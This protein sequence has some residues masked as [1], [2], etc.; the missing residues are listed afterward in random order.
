MTALIIA[1]GM[2]SFAFM[3]SVRESTKE[4][5]ILNRE[6]QGPGDGA[7]RPDR[8]DLAFGY[9]VKDGQI[10]HRGSGSPLVG[11]DIK[12]FQPIS[13]DCGKDKNTGYIRD[14][15]VE[16]S[17]PDSF[18]CL[19]GA[20][21]KDKAHV[22]FGYNKIQTVDDADPASFEIIHDPESPTLT[23]Y[24]RDVD[25]VFYSNGVTISKLDLDPKAFVHI[26]RAYARDDEKVFFENVE[27]IGAEPRTF[28]YLGQAGGYLYEQ[29]Y[30]TDQHNV[31]RAATRILPNLDSVTT[32][33]TGL[34]LKDASHVY[35]AQKDTQVEGADA[36]T[37][38]GNTQRSSGS[39]DAS[40]KNFIYL[41]GERAMR[42]AAGMEYL[43]YFYSKDTERVFYKMEEI[44]GADLLT[45]EVLNGNGIFTSEII[46]HGGGYAKDINA[47][48]YNGAKIPEADSQTFTTGYRGET[49]IGYAEDRNNRYAHGEKMKND[50]VKCGT[51]ARTL[52]EGLDYWQ[53]KLGALGSS[54]IST[55]TSQ[56]EYCVLPDGSRL[57]GFVP[58]EELREGQF[59][60]PDYSKRKHFYWLDSENQNI[61]DAPVVLDC[62]EGRTLQYS[63]DSLEGGV[64]KIAC[65]ENDACEQRK[66]YQIDL[67]T[68][69]NAGTATL[70]PTKESYD[71]G[72][73]G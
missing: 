53:G 23:R 50:F 62:G 45:F 2:I 22:F 25:D 43:G 72:Y 6:L 40:D 10:Y 51:D 13:E 35:L 52:S 37:F 70:S 12:T 9:Y 59:G 4:M 57:I 46:T 18:V 47:A 56:F 14:T 54:D 3:Q 38:I 28:R 7:G 65:R 71:C 49:R 58:R 33:L 24:S 20:Y 5:E 8:S 32:E 1:T 55:S 61:I 26:D 30:G 64:V 11:V 41:L 69:K 16:G 39:G 21:M 27:V 68:L 67:E 63:L 29:D 34:Y 15:A 42:R 19:E 44:I 17:L 66:F 36:S 60:S 48:Y 73:R 31:Y